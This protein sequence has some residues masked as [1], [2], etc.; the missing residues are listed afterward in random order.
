MGLVG[1]MVS[2]R[3]GRG[4]GSREGLF[5]VVGGGSPLRLEMERKK[6]KRKKGDG[7]KGK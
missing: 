7:R 2:R 6:T 1:R 5:G 4:F 3:E